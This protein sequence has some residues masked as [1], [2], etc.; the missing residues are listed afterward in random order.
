MDQIRHKTPIYSGSVIG[1]GFRTDTYSYLRMGDFQVKLYENGKIETKAIYRNK[2]DAKM[3]PELPFAKIPPSIR[4]K[5]F[6]L[7]RQIK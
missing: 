3:Y 7:H 4:V 1:S 6:D 2:S 5:D